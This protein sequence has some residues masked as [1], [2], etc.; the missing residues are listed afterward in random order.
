M[1]ETGRYEVEDGVIFMDTVSL[2]SSVQ[3]SSVQFHCSYENE[4]YKMSFGTFTT[5]RL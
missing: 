4:A 1:R 3:F 5:S 2:F